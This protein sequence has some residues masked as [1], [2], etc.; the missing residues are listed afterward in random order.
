MRFQLGAR[1]DAGRDL[2]SLAER[3]AEDFAGRAAEHD[4]EASYPFE[5]V[6]ALRETGY[7]AAPVPR[8][9]GGLGVESVHDLLVASSRLARGDA[10]VTIGLNM[11]LIPVVSMAH[12]WRAPC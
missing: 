6:R 12:R 10:A 4:R 3:L 1:T 11:H 5:N 8:E 9:L 7:L 2:V